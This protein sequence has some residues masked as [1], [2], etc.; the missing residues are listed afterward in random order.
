MFESRKKLSVF[1]MESFLLETFFDIRYFFKLFPALKTMCLVV[2]RLQRN[3]EMDEK[4]CY[5]PLLAVVTVD[6]TWEGCPV[7]SN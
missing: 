7:S 2:T 3:I 4:F 6:Q 5:H 1:Q